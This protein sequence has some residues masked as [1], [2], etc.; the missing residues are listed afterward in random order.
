M[1]VAGATFACPQI[2]FKIRVAARHLRHRRDGGLT[3]GRPSQVRVD[4]DTGRIDDAT[5]PRP[6]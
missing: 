5:R 4:D 3:Q 2:V 1:R 6:E